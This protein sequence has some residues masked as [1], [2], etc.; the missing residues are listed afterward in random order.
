MCV[1]YIV[2]IISVSIIM[3]FR[4]T[5]RMNIIIFVDYLVSICRKKERKKK[6]RKKRKER[7]TKS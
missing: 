2:V 3:T 1:L 4:F 5:A 7:K 6:E